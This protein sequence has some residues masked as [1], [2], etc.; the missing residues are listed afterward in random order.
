M[1]D[2]R[3]LLED[4]KEYYIVIWKG[5]TFCNMKVTL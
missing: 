2:V 4:G 1:A 3:I 5:N